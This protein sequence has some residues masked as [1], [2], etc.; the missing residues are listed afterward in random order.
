M[1]LKLDIS[2]LSRA[3]NTC[4]HERLPNTKPPKLFGDANAKFGAVPHFVFGADCP[5]S[6]GSDN[7]IAHDCNKLSLMIAFSFFLERLALLRRVRASLAWIGKQ[8][9]G[10]GMRQVKIV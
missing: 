6:G 2:C 10:L 3:F 1:K 7:C 9:V 8:V 5:D 4:R